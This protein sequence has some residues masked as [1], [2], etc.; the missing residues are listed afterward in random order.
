ML[1][2][3]RR[4]VL[5]A[6]LLAYVHSLPVPAADG[7]CADLGCE[8]RLL[9]RAIAAED[10]GKLD[11]ATELYRQFIDEH[12]GVPAA[13]YYLGNLYFDTGRRSE[14]ASAFRRG[15]SASPG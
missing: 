8:G 7:E 2:T 15:K 9:E 5:S 12:P 3:E 4:A 14:A 11:E 13:Y 6:V 1:S 10:T